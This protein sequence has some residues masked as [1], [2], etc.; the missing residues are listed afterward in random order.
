M[1]RAHRRPEELGERREARPPNASR[2]QAPRERNRVDHRARETAAG[3]ALDLAAEEGDVE[4]RVVRDEHRV[5]GER[6]EATNRRARGGAP[7]RSESRSPVSA[8]MAGG[9]GVFGSTNV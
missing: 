9:N 1:A 6:E 7:R 8:P 2:Q 5:A 3:E 4:A